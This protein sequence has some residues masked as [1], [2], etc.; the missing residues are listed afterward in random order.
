M[1]KT[2]G[3][4]NSSKYRPLTILCHIAILLETLVLI[5]IKPVFNHILVDDTASDQEDQ[6]PAVIKSY[7]VIS[8]KYSLFTVKYRF[9]RIFLKYL[10]A[11]ITPT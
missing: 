7:P 8:S 6:P 5:N 3:H 4:T 1:L 9:I 10:T 11:L 2:G